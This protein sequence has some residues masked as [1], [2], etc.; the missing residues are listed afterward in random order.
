MH[1]LSYPKQIASS[2]GDRF[3]LTFLM[4]YYLGALWVAAIFLAAIGRL[5]Y[6]PLEI[7]GT[8]VVFL[9]I[10]IGTNAILAKTFNAAA[11]RES[12]IITALI[13]GLIVGPVVTLTN[14]PF[15]AFLSVVAMSSKY[16]LAWNEKHIFNPA[17]LA[18][19]VTAIV[20]HRG[21]SWWVG[22]PVLIPLTIAGGIILIS[23]F[24]R[25]SLVWS[26]LAAYLGLGLVPTLLSGTTLAALPG[27]YSGLLLQT[28][29]VF[30]T[31]VMLIEPLTSPTRRSS[32]I[33][34][35]AFTGLVLVVLQNFTPVSYSLELALL[36]G[37]IIAR[38]LGTGRRMQFKLLRTVDEGGGIRGYWFTKPTGFKFQPGQ[39]LD[40]T[41]PHPH[42]DSRGNRRWFTIASSPTEDEVLIAVRH[43]VPSSS[44]K[45]A[46]RDTDT[47]TELVAAG[48]AGDFV[49]PEDSS[50]PL[51]WIAGGIGV[52]PFR[53]MAK[54]LSDTRDHRPVTLFYS[55]RNGEGVA[56]HEFFD[57]LSETGLEMVYAISEAPFPKWPHETGYINME[58]ITRH[59]PRYRECLFYLSGPIPMVLAS[60]SMLKAA[61]V[62]ASRIREDYFP[63]YPAPATKQ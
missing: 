55:N 42:T 60:A 29:I 7:F 33:A 11:N 30:F 53:S 28:P 46:L 36:I 14:L 37:N 56:F 49:L 8:T 13:L 61:G 12:A 39:Y 48:A 62:P 54:Y 32:R 35:G 2:I 41:L 19:V 17:A 40:W 22:T 50:L 9:G 15:L 1:L 59:A 6:N 45:A 26:F 20:L 47:G 43:S 4:R 63:G 18:V 38:V 25:W 51:I 44:F 10:C 52:T 3:T 34:F 5:P 31:C 27:V 57:D 58:M 23:K 21:A 24:Q 16:L